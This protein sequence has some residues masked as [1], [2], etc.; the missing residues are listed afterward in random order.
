MAEIEN[1]L[2]KGIVRNLSRLIILCLLSHRPYSGYEMLKEIKRV[3]G[4]NFKPGVIYPLL[5]EL[6][7]GKYI[8]GEKVQKG[9]R[10]MIY[11]S[12]TERGMK[13]L[14]DLRNLF[15]KLPIGAMLLEFLS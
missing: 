2:V 9:R 7:E 15:K 11:Y 8:V 14:E 13:L 1:E 3:T 5:Y 4:Q 6:D 10:Q 12:I